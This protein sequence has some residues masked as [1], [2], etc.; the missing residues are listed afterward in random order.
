MILIGFAKFNRHFVL[1][2]G[3]CSI[4]SSLCAHVTVY[5]INGTQFGEFWSKRCI[6]L[7][8]DFIHLLTSFIRNNDILRQ[9]NWNFIFTRSKNGIFL[10]TMLQ[11]GKFNGTLIIWFPYI[12]LFTDDSVT[13]NFSMWLRRPETFWTLNINGSCNALIILI[14]HTIFSSQ[15]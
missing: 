1:F 4:V 12:F 11:M 15:I 3:Y 6:S 9:K 10:G 13:H 8:C 7:K 5:I 2:Q 14:T